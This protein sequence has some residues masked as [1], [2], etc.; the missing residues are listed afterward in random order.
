MNAKAAKVLRQAL[1]LVGKS[2][3]EAQ[4]IATKQN[5]TTAVLHPRCGKS[6]YRRLKAAR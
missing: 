6:A 3:R 5:P 2:F 1:Q 4:Y